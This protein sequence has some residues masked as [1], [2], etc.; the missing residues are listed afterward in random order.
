MY[1]TR[2][3]NHERFLNG[4]EWLPLSYFDVNCFLPFQSIL[5]LLNF[6]RQSCMSHYNLNFKRSDLSY[7]AAL[8]HRRYS[9]YW[10]IYVPLSI[11]KIR[12]RSQFAFLSPEW[13]LFFSQ[14]LWSVP[15]SFII[16]S[17]DCITSARS[18]FDELISILE[19]P[20]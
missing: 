9:C 14:D 4:L 16:D 11:M 7:L 20:F 19:F 18:E 6:H 8:I 3:L 17:V 10:L 15:Y 1:S 12:C 13:C 5:L 2:I